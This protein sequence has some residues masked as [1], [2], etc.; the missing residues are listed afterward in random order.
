MAEAKN[1]FI[2]SKM[3]KDLDERLIPNNEY[4]DALN[5][6]VSRS[7]GSDVGAVESILGNEITAVG[8]GGGFSIIGTY[9]DESSN[10]L[11]YFRTNHTNCS[12][13]APLTATCTIGFLQTR[14]NT[15]T[16]LVSG[17]FLNFCKGSRMEGISLI[18][19]Q[20]FFTDNRNQPRKINVD[21]SLGYYFNEDQISVAKYAPLSPPEFL[22]LRADASE[23]APPFTEVLLPSTMSDAADPSVVELGIYSISSSN[24]AVKRYRNGDAIPEA[25]S[26]TAWSDA[27]T[28][29][30]GRWCYYANYNGNGTTYGLLYNK[31]AVIDSRGLAPIGHRIPTAAEFG[32]ITSISG[33]LSAPYKSEF[34]WDTPG[35]DLNGFSALPGGYRNAAIGTALGFSNLTTEAR[36]WASDTS[37]NSYFLFPA[38]GGNVSIATNGS[39]LDGYSVRVLKDAGYTG[40]TGDPDYIKDKFVK[41]AYRFKFDDNE[42]SIVSPFS[43]DVFIP[44]QE[45]QFVNDDENLAFI[46]TVV[47]FMQNSINNAVLN[48]KLPCIDIINNYKIKSLDII[49]KQSDMQAYQVI[50]T[51][52]VDANFITNLKYTNIYQYSYESRH[53]IRTLPVSQSVRVYD[54]VPVKALAQETSGNRIMYSNYL[55]GYS[56]PV[57]LDY[58]V[59]TTEKSAQQYVEYPQHSIKQNRNY[60][61]GVILADKYGRQ[62]DIILSNYDGLLDAN[63]DPQPGSNYFYDYKAASFSND[64]QPWQ[65]DN[66]ALYYL[67]QI[68][69][70]INANGVSGYPGAYAKGNYYTV[71]ARTASAPSALYP[72][73]NSEGT[74]CTVATLAQVNFDTI[75]IYADAI[76]AANTFN[77]FIDSGNGWV[78]QDPAL[79]TISQD[80]IYT[81]I[82]F[83]PTLTGEVTNTT[84]NPNVNYSLINLTP[85]SDKPSIGST[86]TG[87]GIATGTTVLSYDDATSIVTISTSSTLSNGTVLTFNPGVALDSTVKFEVLYT[88][89]NLYKYTTGAASSTN[90]PLFPTWPTTY[91]TYYAVGKKL[92]GLYIDYTEITSVTPI[93]DSG[94]VRAVDFFTKEEVATNYLFDMTPT[95]RPEPSIL[96]QEKTFVTYDIN[97]NGFYGYKF[98]TKQQQQDYYNVYLPGIINGYPIKGETKEQGDTAYSTLITDNINKIPRNLEDVGPLQNQFTSDVSLFGRVTNINTITSGVYETGNRQFDPV[99]SADQ[100]DLVGTVTDLFPGLIYDGGS[101]GGGP[102]AGEVN[103]EAVYNYDTKPVLFQVS[104][105]KAIGITEDQYTTPQLGNGNF[106]YPPD[107]YLAVYETA[108]Y[109]SPL[110]IFYESSTS[111][112]VSDLNESLVNENTNITG[113]STFTSNFP[114]SAQIGTVITTDFFPTAGGVNVTT[115]SL[116]SY[117]VYN[118]FDQ[119]PDTGTLDTTVLQNSGFNVEAGSSVGSFR[120]VTAERFYAGSSAEAG[121]FVDWRG[122]YQF[123][124]TF[125]QQDGVQSIQTLEIDLE[126]V[127]PVIDRINVT[128][129]VTNSSVQIV[130]PGPSTAYAQQSNKGRNGSARDYYLGDTTGSTGSTFELNPPNNNAWEVTRITTENLTTGNTVVIP[131]NGDPI[132]DY[133]QVFAGS[134]ASPN[135]Q[136]VI[137]NGLDQWLTFQLKGALNSQGGQSNGPMNTANTR[138]LINMRLTDTLGLTNNTAT[139]GYDVSA[140]TFF[141]DLICTPYLTGGNTSGRVNNSNASDV[142]NNTRIVQSGDPTWIGQI[143]NWT[144]N[145]VYLY[146]QATI[147]TSSGITGQAKATNILGK[148]GNGLTSIPPYGINAGGTSSSYASV[149]NTGGGGA[150]GNLVQFASLAPFTAAAAGVSQANFDLAVLNGMRPGGKSNNYNLPD[151]SASGVVGVGISLV[152][153]GGSNANNVYGSIIASTLSNSGSPTNQAILNA[154]V[155]GGMQYQPPISPPWYESA[156]SGS[157]SISPSVTPVPVTP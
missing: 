88:S 21:Q 22:N 129:T 131:D 77:V 134:T 16:V 154:G 149:G 19:N 117:T 53:A 74:Q 110:E 125:V 145:T 55:E 11:Y 116:S 81:D 94:G 41:F 5:I 10:R 42:Y 126:N 6:A 66:L 124:L 99:P 14:T 28:A 50:E 86:V 18:E 133:I 147:A 3:N 40:W 68:P 24:L 142:S 96:G 30:E 155:P 60:Q 108:P 12:V 29:Q 63:G 33:S 120:I 57:G 95:T 26:Q 101:T 153:Q 85:S 38:N 9:A 104:T 52:K 98:A 109:V 122:K 103:P 47:E 69:E 105:Q 34:L 127:A 31:W 82:D 56:A 143:Q 27:D 49:F 48:I 80:G 114:E 20:L 43:Q 70:T 140:A 150:S 25:T 36:F 45:G 1:N 146:V 121:Y 112:L 138:Y 91:S 156:G 61:V 144:T 152:M 148:Y 71:D 113:I 35:N 44:Y 51:I 115:A 141:G 123:N 46:T 65:G 23:Q 13:K 92:R 128:A 132:S 84:G 76:D 102:Q 59:S 75:I 79:Y 136:L 72:Y 106:P 62:T 8:E 97:V 7:E 4:R 135:S 83:L 73:F 93:S 107:M 111:E 39:T 157:P 32:Q 15:N 118:Y 89:A 2:K 67:Q 54:K 137:P 17:S 139:I 151:A 100:V 78:L 90:R 58:Y 37:S 119:S 87:T 130:Q 64:V